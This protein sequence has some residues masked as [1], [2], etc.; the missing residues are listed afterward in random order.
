MAKRQEQTPELV[1]LARNAQ[2]IF[3]RFGG[4][5]DLL[6][7]DGRFAD[8]L[9]L[10]VYEKLPLSGWREQLTVLTAPYLP[11]LR[12]GA[13]QLRAA[14][15]ADWSG[16]AHSLLVH[17]LLWTVGGYSLLKHLDS[18]A[19]ALVV[20][21]AEENGAVWPGFVRSNQEFGVSCLIGTAYGRMTD[22]RTLLD[23]ADVAKSL[24]TLQS[25]RSLLVR[26]TAVSRFL[27][28]V[29]GLSSGRSDDGSYQVTWPMMAAADLERVAPE[30]F[31]LAAGLSLLQRQTVTPLL[32]VAPSER[33]EHQPADLA[34]G[35]YALLVQ[36]LVEDW[37]QAQILPHPE[38]PLLAG[39]L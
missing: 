17:W 2:D 29:S 3:Q 34:V 35:I 14:W 28:R 19:L 27:N 10:P 21:A 23:G 15:L 26:T 22:L 32:A 38:Q 6:V 11:E 5:P 20:T 39:L 4:W 18:Q 7:T 8:Q 33:P 37:V 31:H 25:D 24:A 9:E 36:L 13:E 16:V 12:R 30:L 1:I